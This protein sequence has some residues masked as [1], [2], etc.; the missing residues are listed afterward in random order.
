MA[1]E[2]KG[3]S[4]MRAVALLAT[5]LAVGSWQAAPVW[6]AIIAQHS[7][8]TDPSTEGFTNNDGL[9]PVYGSPTGDTWTIQGNPYVTYDQYLITPAQAAILNS[10]PT[11]IY[12]AT[13]NNFY[14]NSYNSGEIGPFGTYADLELNGN[15]FN[16][17]LSSDGAGDQLLS[18]SYGSQAPSYTISG[19]GTGS[20]TLSMVW[21]NTTS[22][23]NVYLDGVEI[24]S[25]YGGLACPSC[26]D[27]TIDG[28]MFF[29]GGGGSFSNVEL[30]TSNSIPEPATWA[31]ML[32]GFAALGLAGITHHARAL[33]FGISASL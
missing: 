22:L 24:I 33:R 10:A 21:N 25:N 11:L 5:V 1:G 7:G 31:M 20:V 12:T 6:A 17:N 15:R 28:F 16:L 4:Q 3:D 19:L 30:Q 8:S 2:T 13:F 9:L 26:R 14:N 27:P 18:L 32:A 29:G 23:A